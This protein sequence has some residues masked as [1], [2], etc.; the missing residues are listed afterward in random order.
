[1]SCDNIDTFDQDFAFL[2]ESFEYLRID[3]RFGLDTVFVG[4]DLESVFTSD[5]ADGISGVDFHFVHM[6]E[7]LGYR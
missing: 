4:F 3:R 7:V 2:W 1:M 6:W 5:D